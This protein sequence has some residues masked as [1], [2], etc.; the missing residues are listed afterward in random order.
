MNKCRPGSNSMAPAAHEFAAGREATLRTGCKLNL[1]LEITGILPNGYHSLKTF[2]L[3]LPPEP[4]SPE[5][6]DRLRLVP[7]R[8]GC[9]GLTVN[10]CANWFDPQNNTLQ[11]AYKIYAA[12]AGRQ[13]PALEIELTKGVPQGAGLGG[14]SANAAAVLLFLESWNEVYGLPGLG[15]ESLLR[16][17]ARVGADVPCFILNRPA[18]AEGIGDLLTPA[19]MPFAGFHLVLVCPEQEVSTAWAYRAW[20]ELKISTDLA[21]NLSANFGD[22]GLTSRDARDSNF[23]SALSPPVAL[24]PDELFNSFE[25]V[26]FAHFPALAGIRQKLLEYGAAGALMSGSGSSMFGLFEQA[27]AAKNAAD[28]LKISGLRVYTRSIPAGA[29]PSW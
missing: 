7:A 28:A 10:C 23:S 25:R 1:H 13:L 2:F 17:G 14:G 19:T 20:D 4:G 5:L 3:P 24:K 16:L 18:W 12:E 27:G 11:K 22:S 29:S 6:S 9:A 26:V 15:W 8:P 21:A